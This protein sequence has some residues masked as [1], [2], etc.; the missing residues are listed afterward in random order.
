MIPPSRSRIMGLSKFFSWGVWSLAV[1]LSSVTVSSAGERAGA[2]AAVAGQ[3]VRETSSPTQS[4]VVTLQQQHTADEVIVKF[5]DGADPSAIASA[6]AQIQT[7]VVKRFP[8]VPHL[9]L[10][11]L[12]RG[13]SVHGTIAAYYRNPHVEYAEPNYIVYAFGIPN[14]P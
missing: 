13:A 5:K 2:S 9:H 14:D 6:H 3:I 11:R 10:V 8:I 4:G 7:T 1:L 12:P